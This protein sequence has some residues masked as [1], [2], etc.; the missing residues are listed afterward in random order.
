VASVSASRKKVTTVMGSTTRGRLPLDGSC[1]SFRGDAASAAAALGCSTDDPTKGIQIPTT[2]VPVATTNIKMDATKPATS[3]L[4]FVVARFIADLVFHAEVVAV[5]S[6]LDQSE[7]QARQW[8][9]HVCSTWKAL[10]STLI[11][12]WS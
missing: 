1:A 11:G 6:S 9:H 2:V 7:K 12:G 5:A 8:P 3:P 4:L 10:M